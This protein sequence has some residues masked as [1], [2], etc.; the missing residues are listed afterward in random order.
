M[1][2]W[3]FRVISNRLTS[4]QRIPQQDGYASC[5]K[6]S[7]LN[8]ACYKLF[9]LNNSLAYARIG[10][11]VSKK[12]FKLAVARNANKRLVREAFRNHPLSRR[13]FDLVVMAKGGKAWSLKE[14]KLHLVTLFN[15]LEAQCALY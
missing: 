14:K 7:S 13:S 9:Y 15:Q 5:L 12:H 1:Q 11:A 10:V 2:D 4:A 8:N 6:S 3:L